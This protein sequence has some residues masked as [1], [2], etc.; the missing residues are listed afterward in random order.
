[1]ERFPKI[2]F[3]LQVELIIGKLKLFK[4]NTEAFD[5]ECKK[6]KI[7]DDPNQKFP[8]Y[9]SQTSNELRKV[10][11]ELRLRYIK[12]PFIPGVVVTD[13]LMYFKQ[14]IDILLEKYEKIKEEQN[15]QQKEYERKLRKE[16]SKEW[17]EQGVLCEHCELGKMEYF[18]TGL[19][20][21][22]VHS[23]FFGPMGG[24]LNFNEDKT[25][26][27]QF[28]YKKCEYCGHV[29]IVEYRETPSWLDDLFKTDIKFKKGDIINKY[30]CGLF[31]EDGLK[32]LDYKI[33]RW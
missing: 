16:K 15:E 33:I 7:D 2:K 32:Y 11:K 23:E 17:S 10:L 18:E 6:Y 5:K 26:E 3:D 14:Y 30:Q 20:E 19:V 12:K 28:H 24:G 31:N 1:M 22:Y 27:Y 21:I 13:E 9:K 29:E 8:T 25:R 4:E